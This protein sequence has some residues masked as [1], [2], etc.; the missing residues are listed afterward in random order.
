MGFTPTVL[1]PISSNPDATQLVAHPRHGSANSL[2]FTYSS[3]TQNNLPNQHL[4]N[5]QGPD[6]TEFHRT[7]CLRF[8]RHLFAC[9]ATKPSLQT[10][11]RHSQVDFVSRNRFSVSV[12]SSWPTLD[13]SCNPSLRVVQLCNII[14]S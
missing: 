8:V 13:M 12:I 5:P 14:I 9:F 3:H 10:W 11:G 2:L 4:S 6:L 7:V 1:F